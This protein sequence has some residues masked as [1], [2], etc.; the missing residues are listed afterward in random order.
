MDLCSL[1]Y[2]D[3]SVTKKIYRHYLCFSSEQAALQIVKWGACKCNFGKMPRNKKPLK[4]NTRSYINSSSIFW[5]LGNDSFSEI[6]DYIAWNERMISERLIWKDMEGS[7]R[8]IILRF[9]S[10]ISLEGLG[11]PTKNLSHDSRSPGRN[12]NTGSPSSLL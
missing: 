8:G 9:Y 3:F 6:Q 10:A 11:K 12:L 5:G 4:I 1:F 2:D 7:G